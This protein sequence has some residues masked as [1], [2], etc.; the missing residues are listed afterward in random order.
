MLKNQFDKNKSILNWA[1]L[2]NPK[3]RTNELSTWNFYTFFTKVRI[4]SIVAN[5]RVYY[6]DSTSSISSSRVISNKNINMRRG[7]V[8]HNLTSIEKSLTWKF[9]S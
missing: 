3:N 4:Y 2:K 6:I 7:D 5:A 9:K 8:M 1:K